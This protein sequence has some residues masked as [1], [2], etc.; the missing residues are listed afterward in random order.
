MQTVEAWANSQLISV[1]TCFFTAF[2]TVQMDVSKA[3]S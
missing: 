2:T 1:F 3:P